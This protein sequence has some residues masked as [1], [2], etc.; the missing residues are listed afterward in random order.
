[1]FHHQIKHL[2][3]RQKYSAARRIFNSLLGVSSVSSGDE[4]Q[5]LMLDISLPRVSVGYELAI[6]MSYPASA[7]GIIVLLQTPSKYRELFP[8][9]FVKTTDFRLVFNFEQRRTVT[10]FGEH[11]IMAH[12]P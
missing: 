9:L 7:S 1:V 2:E 8:T 3:V 11:G 6:I 4:T 5:C 12:I 10:V